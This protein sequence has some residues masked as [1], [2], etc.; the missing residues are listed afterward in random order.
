[1]KLQ[2]ADRSENDAFNVSEIHV[3]TVLSSI[4]LYSSVLPVFL[5]DIGFLIWGNKI[6]VNIL[7]CHFVDTCFHF[8]RVNASHF[9]LTYLC[10]L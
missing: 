8:S 3:N 5:T 1:M 4:A 7:M 10:W 9:L 6:A 2:D